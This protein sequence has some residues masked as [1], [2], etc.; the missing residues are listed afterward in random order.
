MSISKKK[1]NELLK[2]LFPINRSITGKGN[3]ETLS[4]LKEF[5]P[6][7]V[8]KFKS[9]T[10][11]YD[12]KVPDEWNASEAWIKD[13]SGKKIVDF[14]INNLHL[15]SYSKSIHK[16]ISFK[17]LKKHIFYDHE[18]SKSIPYRTSYYRKT[19]GFCVNRHQ[20][21]YLESSKNKLEVFI[22][23][24]FNPKGYMHYG[25]LILKG[26]RKKE[27]LISTYICH[28]SM[29]NDNL[30]GVV[31]TV[32][33]ANEILKIRNRVNSYRII[34]IP[35]TIGAIAYCKKNQIKM[36]NI[37][38]GLVVTTVAG[39]GKYSLKESWNNKHYINQIAKKVL[40]SESKN[41]LTYPFDIHG[42][43]ERQYSSQGFRINTISISKSK[44]YDYKEYHTSLD[45]L[46]F[47]KT[48]YIFK[49]LK[50]YKKIIDN[51]E[52]LEI[53]SLNNKYCEPMLSKHD[54]YPKVGGK[55]K[56]TL[57]KHSSLD[58]ILWLI[59]LCDGKTSID[60]VLDKIRIKKSN[61]DK[62]LKVLVNKNILKKI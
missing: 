41:Y 7:K 11:V 5:I 2:F 51:L 25:E 24:Q 23:S 47:I 48:D 57:G 4:A 59:F 16:F 49:S 45:N 40:S 56:P 17:E 9:G 54:L 53:Y 35:E 27:I 8:K 1:V 43:D 34:F 12:W 15:V 52:R 36:K 26:K 31:M 44:Y 3:L 38:I 29:A 13:S 21:K 58:I 32:L 37:D 6:L 30:S 62:I 14:K 28:P 42:S 55:I 46:N 20:Y 19:W 33:L 10:K 39:R 61:L 18:N 22:K 50:I 60:E